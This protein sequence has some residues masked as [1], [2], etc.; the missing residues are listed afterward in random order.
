MKGGQYTVEIIHLP[1]KKRFCK[2]VEACSHK[3]AR[4]YSWNFVWEFRSDYNLW[5]GKMKISI[6]KSPLEF[7]ELNSIYFS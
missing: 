4:S 5:S 3:D 1:T 2:N 6:K 7:Y